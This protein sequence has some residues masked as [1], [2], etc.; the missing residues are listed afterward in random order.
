M[1]KLVTL[2]LVIILIWYCVPKFHNI[3]DRNIEYRD[4]NVSNEIQNTEAISKEAKKSYS[5]DYFKQIKLGDTKE[6]LI[7]QLGKPNRIDESEY[8]F[9]W[10]VYNQYKNKFAMV[11]VENNTVVALYC[12]SINSDEMQ[13][14][15]IGDNREEIRK[16]YQPLEYKKKGNT[17][18]IIT[19][20]DQYDIFHIENKYITVFYDIY[21]ENQVCSYQIIR[22]DAENSLDSMYP[23]ESE[24]LKKSYEL[25]TI[26]LTNSV[27]EKRGLNKLVY[28]EMATKSSRKHSLDM[29]NENYFDHMNKKQQT[30]FDRM[31][32][33]GIVYRGAG[34][35]IA[36]GQ[37]SAIYAHEA[38]M[39]SEGHRKNI[40][41]NYKYIG[42]GV[43]FGGHY[44]I[45]YTQNFYI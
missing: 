39:N 17:R 13:N 30:P 6:D 3:L 8:S 40:L 33:E 1:K 15:K 9:K 18:Y 19:S 42:V 21:N 32:N 23:N 29:I 25:Q 35:N 4:T 28:S 38:W 2:L 22:D 5:I 45:Y 37:A 12:N 7:S 26:D 10:Y 14:I 11:G 27:R 34:E 20:N 16:V 41:G 31:K 44:T 43:E 36:A 24:E